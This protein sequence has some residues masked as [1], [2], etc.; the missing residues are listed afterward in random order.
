MRRV[1][2]RFFSTV[3]VLVLFL[4]F[5]MH[6]AQIKHTHFT[7]TGDGVFGMAFSHAHSDASPA[8]KHQESLD[9]KMHMAEKKFVVFMLAAPLLSLIFLYPQLL[10]YEYIRRFAYVRIYRWQKRF[11]ARMYFFLQYFYARGLLNP[12]LY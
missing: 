8:S 2:Q 5:G 7:P 3:C 10:A 12:K 4:S 6:A 11:T 1:L 9:E